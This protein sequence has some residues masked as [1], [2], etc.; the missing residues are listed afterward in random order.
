MRL[1]GSLKSLVYPKIMPKKP[2]NLLFKSKKPAK[3]LVFKN[4]QNHFKSDLDKLQKVLNKNY[5]K[6][7]SRKAETKGSWLVRP[8]SFRILKSL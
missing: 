3:K 8:T 5:V 4:A 1:Q 7:R 6:A 2:Q